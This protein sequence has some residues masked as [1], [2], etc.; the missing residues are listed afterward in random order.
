VSVN[1]ALLGCIVMD[2]KTDTVNIPEPSP[3]LGF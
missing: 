3:H 1:N 2:G